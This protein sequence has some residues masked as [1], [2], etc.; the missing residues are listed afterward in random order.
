M[1]KFFRNIR[2]KFIKEGRFI[3]YLKYA[4]GEIFLVVIGITNVVG[5][6]VI[7]IW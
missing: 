7:E 6:A 5:W 2:Y 3:N 1:L 4:V